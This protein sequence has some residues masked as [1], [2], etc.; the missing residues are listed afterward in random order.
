M[1]KQRNIFLFAAG[2]VID[3]NAPTTNELTRLVRK[4]G[5]KTT[6]NK[7]TITEFIYNQL[8]VNQY[9]ENDINFET[10]I[11]VIEEL[12]VYYSSFNSE[13]K[14]NS[15]SSILFDS[16]FERE[17]LNFSVEGNEIIHG[18]K[19]EI[20]IGNR[21]EFAK[22]AKNNESP[23]QFFFQQL[24]AEILDHIINRIS[25]YAYHSLGDS[26]IFEEN[27]VIN[28][29]FSNWIKKIY[30]DTILRMYTL[31][32][33]RNFKIIL[34]KFDES[35]SIFD[36]FDIENEIK[37]N[38]NIPRILN[39]KESNVHYNLHGCAFWNVEESD[40]NPYTNPSFCLK[41]IPVFASNTD[42]YRTWQSEKGKS[43]MLTNIITG[44]QKTQRG[45]FSPFKQMQA[46]FDEDCIF[47]DTIF[48]IGYSFNDEHINSSIKNA[49]Q[50][51]KD[52]KFIIIDPSFT[53]NDFDLNVM[54]KIF[55]CQD[56]WSNS[57]PKTIGDNLH[58]FY[59][60]RFLVHT[61]TFKDFL[62]VI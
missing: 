52:V 16:K 60:G 6:D 56:H 1:S 44:Y 13:K 51:N 24:L 57:N 26:N 42:E 38:A 43:I 50:Y 53:K 2:A 30:G 34:E 25:K 14:V 17:L 47:A 12:I 9:Q 27:N 10:I 49:I 45:I 18:F 55:S 8:I 4:V 11:N 35:N 32:Y 22:T 41:K 39:D 46:A 62:K 36:G 33:D 23:E 59:D 61:K 19:L 37:F 54:N 20:P 58:S 29:L 48:I 31:N 3:W 40:G 5:F 28:E 21:L 15:I 7:T